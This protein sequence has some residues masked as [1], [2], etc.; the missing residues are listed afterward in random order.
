MDVK[1]DFR[2][3]LK[4]D[5]ERKGLTGADIGR[6][7][8]ITQQAVHRWLE[9]GFPPVSKLSTLLE[10]LGPDSA[11]SK[12]DH[13][14]LYNER[15]RARVY[16]TEPLPTVHQ[17]KATPSVALARI[18][19]KDFSTAIPEHLRSNLERV[20]PTEYG[21]AALDYLGNRVAAEVV[22]VTNA[23]ASRNIHAAMLRLVTL[24]QMTDSR[25]Q[26]LLIV[27]TTDPEV[28]LNPVVLA[29][30]QV[31]NVQ[32]VKVASGAEAAQVV[33]NAEDTKV[34]E[35]IEPDE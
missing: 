24:T 26:M 16:W 9:R 30:A 6:A 27:V 31:F 3:A 21:D 13:A 8:G 18:M 15:S 2:Q 32:I 20:V 25:L 12:L 10:L 23:F 1:L 34:P 4:L 14:E 28:R 17:F 19:E 22:M 33:A 29:A 5:M 11:V 35:V 7:M